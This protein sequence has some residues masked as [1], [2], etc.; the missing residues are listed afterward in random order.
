MYKDICNKI[1]ADK[2]V[3]YVVSGCLAATTHLTTLLVLHSYLHVSY[4][5]S[6]TIGFWVGFFVSYVLQKVWTFSNTSLI[7][8]PR[9]LLYYAGIACIN[10][11]INGI[12]MWVFVEWA[13][14]WV[15][16]AQV[17]TI[18][19]IATET[20]LILHIVFRKK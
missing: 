4:L 20:Y 3:R 1:L 12:L 15:S 6:S 9:Q 8:A 13:D 2:R 18:G 7:Q 14:V 16:L 17:L 11:L 19:I 10:T 5:T